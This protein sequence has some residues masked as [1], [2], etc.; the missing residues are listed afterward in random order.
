MSYSEFIKS[1]FL[2]HNLDIPYKRWR[3]ILFSLITIVITNLILELLSRAIGSQSIAIQIEELQYSRS[4]FN[5]VF[6]V[7]AM[8]FIEESTFRL[9]LSGKPIHV[10]ISLS[11]LFSTFL[12]WVIIVIFQN[13]IHYFYYLVGIFIFIF[14]NALLYFGLSFMQKPAFYLRAT[15][16]VKNNV[17]FC[18]FLSSLFFAIAHLLFQKIYTEI[19]VWIFGLL[20]I[21][22]VI[23]GI[24]LA[25]IRLQINFVAALIF[26]A[27]LNLLTFI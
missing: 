10:L 19:P 13:D 8:P 26:H 12:L 2:G 6:V 21:Y 27:F 7:A 24:I 17:R 20:F 9:F 14:F 4:I 5:L 25:F 15:T 16:F 11:L 3:I 1:I 18:F 22:Y 23:H